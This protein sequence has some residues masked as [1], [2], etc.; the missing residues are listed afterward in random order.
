MEFTKL[1][2]RGSE[3]EFRSRISSYLDTE[4]FL[5]YLGMSAML[6]NLDSPF[7][8]PQNFYMY[9]NP[10][11]KKITFIPWDLDLAFAAWPFGGSPEQQMDLSLMHPHV[12]QHKLI[13]RLLAIKEVNARYH[14]LLKE[15]AEGCFSK[16][17]LLKNIEGVEDA[18]KQP[19]ARE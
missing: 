13:D 9:L 12:E 5:R 10:A 11:N 15:M 1:V 2:E 4:E 17:Q 16:E 6:V 7:A 18:T 3:E 14:D 8:M 19:Y